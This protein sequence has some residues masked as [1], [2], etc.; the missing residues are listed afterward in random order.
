V[1]LEGLAELLFASYLCWS[2]DTLWC[3]EIR[4]VNHVVSS[5]PFFGAVLSDQPRFTRAGP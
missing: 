5:L 4:R 2:F 1:G 3:S